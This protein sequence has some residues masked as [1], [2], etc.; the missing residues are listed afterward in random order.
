LKN[1]GKATIGVAEKT[2]SRVEFHPQYVQNPPT[3]EWHKTYN[4]LHHDT[5]IS[6]SPQLLFSRKLLYELPALMYL[7]VFKKT[8]QPIKPKKPRKN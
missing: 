4:W 6:F 8:D 7:G 5:T 2:A 1:K 3:E